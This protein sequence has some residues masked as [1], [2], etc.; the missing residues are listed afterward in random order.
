MNS[1]AY[2][3]LLDRLWQ[4]TGDDALLREFYGSVKKS[5]TMTMNLRK[6]PAGVISMPEGNKGME[7]FELGEWAGMCTHLGGMHLAQLRIMERMARHMG[8]EP[9]A[10]QCQAWLAGGSHAME[11]EMWA[12]DYYL[13]YYEKETN[14]KSDDVMSCQLDGEWTAVVH[15]LSGVFQSDRVKTTL[16]T[17][18]RCNIH[19]T[20]E[21]GAATFARLDGTPLV[22]TSKVAAYGVYTMVVAEV[23]L[24]AMIYIQN[25][26]REYGL[27]LAR[28]HWENLVCRQR[29]A[30]D[31][32]NMVRGDTGERHIGTDYY[33]VMILW[34]LPIVLEGQNLTNA[35]GPGSLVDRVIKAG[36]RA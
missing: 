20:P 3:D 8:D 4:R 15:G 23:L 13:N 12:G 17:I 36:N 22:A 31:M 27:E 11:N 32:P 19:V 29:H 25:G 18:K 9:Y 33:Q 14:K 30:W 5:N 34:A 7:W 10:K 1:T 26:E 2:V 28:R 16:Q 6:G 21:V 24:L 35:Y